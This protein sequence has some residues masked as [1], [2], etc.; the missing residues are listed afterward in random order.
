MKLL[1]AS[2]VSRAVAEQRL[3]SVSHYYIGDDPA[4]WHPNVPHYARVKFE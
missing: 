4:R 2:G 3:A 1:G